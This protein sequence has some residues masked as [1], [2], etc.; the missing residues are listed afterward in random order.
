MAK[1]NEYDAIV[2]GSGISG[3]WAAN[4]LTER[5]LKVLMLERGRNV[6]HQKDYI[7]EHKAPWEFKYRGLGDRALF[8]AEYPVQSQCY[9]F[10]E[11][12][13]HFFVNDKEN[14]YTTPEDKP[15][16]WIRGYHVGGRSLMW[17]RQVY[18]W[19]DLDFGANARDG[20]GVD[21]PIRYKEIAPWYDYV[22]KYIGIS[23][24]KEGLSQL[25]DGQFLPPMEMNCV[26]QVVRD[27]VAQAFDDRIVTIGRCAVLTKLHRGRPACHYCGPCHRGCSTGSYF[28]TQSVTLPA[29]RKTGNLTL[30]PYS[31]V[32]SVIYDE[33]VDKATG[34]RVIDANSKEM[35]EFK[36][37]VIFLCASTLGST[38]ILLNSSTNRFPD[39][40]ANSSGAL[41]HYL[42]DHHFQIGATGLYPQFNDRY[43]SGRRPNGVYVPR[44]TN[45]KKQNPD[46][47]R[48]FGM[49]GGAA[50]PSWQRKGQQP[51]FGAEFKNSLREP[52]PWYMRFQAFG[53][54]LPDYDNFV[55]LNHE[56][57][58]AWGLPTLKINCS[59]G[60]NER[61]MRKDM[62]AQA[63]EMLTA[64][65]AENV[66]EWELDDP[67]GLGIH[68]MGTARMGKDPKTSVLNGHN[69]SHDIKNLFVTDGASMA[70]SACQNPSITYMAL[71]ARAV[72]FAVAEM[73]R[74]N[75]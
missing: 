49:Q 54:H 57:T 15:F 16:T 9:A 6:V 24:Q 66:I 64:A 13:Q 10:G 22:E 2:V 31:I 62:K 43:Y 12:T 67:P 4:E 33:P 71:T 44:F 8:K 68:E 5:G 65:G 28:S 32:H 56:L 50:R 61:A 74:G 46:Y 21:W 35:I 42:M 63:A 70:S 38:Q 73:K 1:K 29:A 18:R 37:K 27:R 72:N 58:D 17:A 14:P 23:G 3:G 39:G 47:L 30:R 45:V 36:A 60:E 53:E 69:Q 34:V 75:I 19:S 51:G 20:H 25:P 55:E 11:A 48:G 52:G 59:W 41:G 40:L 7:T 26:E